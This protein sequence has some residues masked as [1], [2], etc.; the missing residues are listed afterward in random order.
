[1]SVRNYDRHGLEN[2]KMEAVKPFDRLKIPPAI[3]YILIFG[4][5]AM[6]GVSKFT[7]DENDIDYLMRRNL[8]LAMKKQQSMLVY[9]ETEISP[10]E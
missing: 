5:V 1:M 9:D 3:L 4:F 7:K 10:A 8:L 2:L 6:I